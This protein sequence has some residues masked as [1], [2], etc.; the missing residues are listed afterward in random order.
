[1]D[2]SLKNIGFFRDLQQQMLLVPEDELASVNDRLLTFPGQAPVGTLSK[3]LQVMAVLLM[4]LQAEVWIATTG[5]SQCS[6]LDDRF[7]PLFTE[8]F[9]LQQKEERLSKVFNICVIFEF[10]QLESKVVE[11]EVGRD[12]ELFLKNEEDPTIDDIELTLLD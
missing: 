4:N 1:M 7:A 2:A 11:F 6:P 3:E 12:F 5:L 8:T 10:P 9:I